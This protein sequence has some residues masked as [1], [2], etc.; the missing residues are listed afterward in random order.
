M[1]WFPV[2][3]LP[4][5]MLDRARVALRTC[6]DGMRFSTYPAFL[7]GGGTGELPMVDGSVQSDLP[8]GADESFGGDESYESNGVSEAK[9]PSR[10]GRNGSPARRKQAC[11]RVLG[12]GP[13]AVPRPRPGRPGPPRAGTPGTAPGATVRQA[14]MPGPA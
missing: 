7:P 11:G 2:G 12:Y 8:F 6:A 10:N 14:S 5:N 13:G 3:D 1:R 4:T 9:G